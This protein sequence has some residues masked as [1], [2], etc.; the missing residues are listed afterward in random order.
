MCDLPVLLAFCS[1]QGQS[2]PSEKQQKHECQLCHCHSASLQ[3]C[4]ER[5][6]VSVCDAGLDLVLAPTL[7]H[8]R[9]A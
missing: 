6:R 4:M 8:G 9:H 1:F 2:V 7:G 5:P 3:H